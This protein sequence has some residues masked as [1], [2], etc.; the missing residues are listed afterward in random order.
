[1]FVII[2][3]FSGAIFQRLSWRLKKWSQ[4][5]LKV[6]SATTKVILVTEEVIIATLNVI[7]ATTKVILATEEVIITTL[8]VIS[9]TTKVISAIKNCCQ[10]ILRLSKPLQS[11]LGH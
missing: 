4:P 9:V 11:D 10:P 7:S 2:F 5:F 6:I 8:N 1:M 3:T